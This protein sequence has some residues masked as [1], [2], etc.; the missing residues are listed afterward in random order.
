[1]AE[2]GDETRH[3]ALSYQIAFGRGPTSAEAAAA[4]DFLRAQAAACDD[5]SAA[6]SQSWT[7][8]CHVLL[9]ANEFLYV[10]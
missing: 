3:V 7:D 10:E 8:F 4:L 6:A 5:A 2:E 1:C 9:N